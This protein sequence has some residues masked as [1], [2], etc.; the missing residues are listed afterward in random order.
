M[1]HTRNLNKRFGNK[2]ALDSL[3]F[4]VPLHQIV[5]VLGPSGCGKTTLL[6]LIAGLERPDSG[7]IEIDGKRV[8]STQCLVA[9]KQRN[10]SMIFQDLALWP[11]MRVLENLT[12]GLK[13]KINGYTMLEDQAKDALNWVSLENMS[14]RYPHQ[15][16]GGERQRLAI[17]RALAPGRPYLLMDEPFSSLDPVLKEDM[18]R[19][20][21]RLQESLQTTILYVTHNL[22]EALALADR[23]LLMSH[24]R[25]VGELGQDE[26]TNL[27]QEDLLIWYKNKLLA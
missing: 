3:D 22:D 25:L 11:H 17:A 16:S 27:S 1:I 7:E 2:L 20:V 10:I 8:S 23:I 14:H 26:L 13:K 18:V 12:F 21:R 15:L 24:G 5:V 4:T 6:R 9:P 19:L